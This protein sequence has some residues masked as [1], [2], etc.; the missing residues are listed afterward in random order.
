ML[1]RKYGVNPVI[2]PGGLEVR[3]LYERRTMRKFMYSLIVA[4]VSLG[5]TA[6]SAHGQTA[7]D[8]L[9]SRAQSVNSL[10]DRHGGM[11]QAI[12]HV[13][14]ETGVP[15]DQLEHMRSQH[16]DAGAAGL[17]IA[18]VI[19]D[20]TKGS[21]ERYL[22]RHIN[23]KGWAGIARENNVPL[24]KIDTKLANLERDLGSLPATGRDRGNQYRN[25]QYRR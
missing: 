22:S 14:V 3:F 16:P 21:P 6:V 23:G 12:H 1:A 7:K 9:E 4:A 18:C 10:A 19:A 15:V 20:N 2:E 24:E 13:S 8:E 5:F 25:D 17:L 11:N